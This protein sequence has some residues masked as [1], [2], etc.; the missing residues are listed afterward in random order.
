[1]FS[2]VT[3]LLPASCVRA[4][5]MA[6]RLEPRVMDEQTTLRIVITIASGGTRGASVLQA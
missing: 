2:L 4:Y 1:M 5:S 6:M 3:P